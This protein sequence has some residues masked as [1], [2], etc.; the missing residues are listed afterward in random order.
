MRGG[1]GGAKRSL[2]RWKLCSGLWW[3]DWGLAR[4]LLLLV[5]IGVV[6]AWRLEY[7]QCD[8]ESGVLHAAENLPNLTTS[9]KGEPDSKIYTT[10]SSENIEVG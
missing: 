8:V 1:I 5:E 6:P 7:I 4:C 10:R 2:S 9:G 3:G